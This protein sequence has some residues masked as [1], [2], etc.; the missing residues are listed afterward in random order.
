MHLRGE[1][2]QRNSLGDMIGGS[3]PCSATT[4]PYA[5]SPRATV[6]S[7]YAERAARAKNSP[8]AIVDLSS[9]R[10]EPFISVNCAALPE[11][12]M[13]SELFGHE[14]GAFTGAHA[15]HPGQIE[16]ADNGTS[17][18]TRSARSP[19]PPKQDAPRSPGKGSRLRG[20]Y[21]A[22]HRFLAPVEPDFAGRSGRTK[23]LSNC[24]LF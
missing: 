6:P 11:T 4:R 20:R 5:A 16:L 24:E 19:R 13:E 7:S 23:V 17:S 2:A 22:M 15:T 8:R 1:L 9:R 3:E 10:G 18:S 14:R 21:P 12:L